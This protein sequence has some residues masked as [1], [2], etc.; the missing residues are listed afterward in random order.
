MPEP[1]D[2]F[3]LRPGDAPFVVA[4]AALDPFPRQLTEMVFAPGGAEAAWAAVRAGRPPCTVP[5]PVATT[6][7]RRAAA[8]DPG[9]LWARHVQAGVGVA[10][11][12]APGYPPDLVDD[13]E[14][15]VVLFHRGDPDVRARPRAA[16]VGTRRASAYGLDLAAAW[17][18]ALSVA[19]VCVVSGL[20]L[21]IDAAAHRG[22]LR[23]PTPP[24]AVVG[25]GL[26][27][28][29]PA[30]NRALW[31]AVATTGLL[32]SEHPLGTPAAAAHFPA[33]NRILA[34]L[35]DV[36][37]VVESHR[38][39]G[40]LL[41]ADAALRRQRTVLAVPGP[42]HSPASTGTNTL[43][44]D[45]ATF[46]CEI[47]DVLMALELA[48]A[49]RRLRREQRPAPDPAGAALLEAFAWAPARLDELA[50]RTGR[51]LLD[52]ADAL[53]ALRSAGWITGGHGWFERIARDRAPVPEVPS[54][55]GGALRA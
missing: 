48:G 29:Y 45:G 38:A 14:A 20:A 35:A 9:V 8:I 53:E 34:A 37:V 25:S 7:R 41:T 2:A 31:E 16:I 19:G 52:T 44:R 49:P 6:W 32:V 11:L 15:P 51:S 40:S 12:D 26:D 23:G 5:D 28:V 43:L 27:R 46:A 24:L 30:R 3:L 4:L 55:E 47:D 1:S 33:R 42:V 21:G 39:G 10:L 50:S 54:P 18:E 13:A 36:V 22:A 17:G